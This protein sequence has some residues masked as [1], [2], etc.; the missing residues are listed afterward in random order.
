LA[1]RFGKSF[2]M[3]E[4]LFCIIA[5]TLIPYAVYLITDDHQGMAVA[6]LVGFCA[7]PC[8]KGAFT[9]LD[10]GAGLNRIL[11]HTARLLLIYS[12]LFSLGWVLCSR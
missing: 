3:S 10:D 5:A 1:V 2:A 4:Y 12:A 9:H 11:G 7:I 6:S 8:V